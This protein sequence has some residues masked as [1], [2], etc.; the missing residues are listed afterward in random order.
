[1]NAD[2]AKKKVIIRF[3]PWQAVN[4]F[5]VLAFGVTYDKNWQMF[6]GWLNLIWSISYEQPK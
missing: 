6:I 5:P 2:N 3:R 4:L 1:M